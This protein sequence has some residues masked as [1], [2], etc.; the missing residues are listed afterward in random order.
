MIK[1]ENGELEVRGNTKDVICDLAFALGAIAREM[2]TGEE[3]PVDETE[4]F[5]AVVVGA[6]RFWLKRKGINATMDGIASHFAD[7][8]HE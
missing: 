6:T 7:H 1:V 8:D 2:G 3:N 4:D 5:I